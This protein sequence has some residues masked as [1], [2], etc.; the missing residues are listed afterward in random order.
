MALGSLP[1]Q[2]PC[3]GVQAFVGG[4]AG[5]DGVLC[6]HWVDPRRRGGLPTG[7]GSPDLVTGVD[8]E[9]SPDLRC[10]SVVIP[11]TSPASG[12]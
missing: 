8:V 10:G 7:L 5:D 4:V 1:S 6:G 9:F 12:G 2:W 11:G 3:T